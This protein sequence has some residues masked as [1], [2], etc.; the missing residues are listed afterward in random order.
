MIPLS[1]NDSFVRSLNFII[2]IQPKRIKSRAENYEPD[3]R[4]KGI[5]NKT[6][7]FNALKKSIKMEAAETKRSRQLCI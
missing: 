1:F 5:V 4:G 3:K 6:K 2:A 7:V